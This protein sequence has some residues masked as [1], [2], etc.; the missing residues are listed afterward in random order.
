MKSYYKT[1]LATKE[2]AI[3]FFTL[4]KALFILQ[5]ELP[6]HYKFET[7]IGDKGELWIFWCTGLF[8]SYKKGCV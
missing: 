7:Q 8:M 5:T 2:D 6:H 1:E 3:R 4:V